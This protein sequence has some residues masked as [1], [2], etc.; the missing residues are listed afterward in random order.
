MT[1]CAQHN[2][3][4]PAGF[5]GGGEQVGDAPF[6]LRTCPSA[7]IPCNERCRISSPTALL[8]SS[9]SWATLVATTLRALAKNVAPGRKPTIKVAN[10]TVTGLDANHSRPSFFLDRSKKSAFELCLDRAGPDPLV[11]LPQHSLRDSHV[12]VSDAVL[13]GKTSNNLNPPLPCS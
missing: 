10:P 5:S 12:I 2:H 3:I 11:C 9:T 1:A 8:A 6:V 4:G 7:G 13:A